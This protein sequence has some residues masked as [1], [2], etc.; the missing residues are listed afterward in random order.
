MSKSS[1]SF[2]ANVL[3]LVT[4]SVFAQGLGVLVAPIVARLFAPEAFGVAALFTSIA[5]IIGVVACLRYQL[6]IM[7]P[8]TDEEAA[9]LLG[10]SLFF[11]LIITGISVLIIFFTGDVIAGMLNSQE[12]KKFLWLVPVSVFVSGIFLALNYWNSRTKQFGRF[13][14]ATVI[15]SV[16]AQTTKLGAGFAGFV[17]G[18]TLIG[19]SILG[20]IVSTFVLGGQIWRDD[21]HLFK[22]SIRWKKMIAGL[23]RHKKF[24]IYSTWS[25]LLNTASQQLP[26]LLLAFYFSPKIVGF[27]ALG[28]AVLSMPMGLVGGAVAQVFF[29]K[30]SE[31]HNHTGNLSKVVEEV[32]K[33]LVSLGIFPILLLTLIGKDLFIV[34]FG[35]RWAEAGVYMQILGLWIFFQFISSPI[36]TLFAVLEKQHYGLLFNSVLFVTRAASLIVGGMT[37]DVRFTLL[38]FASTGVACY[39]FLCFWLISKAELPVMRAFYQIVKYSIYSSPLLISIALVKWL[40]GVQEMGVLLLGLCALLVYYF[41]VMRRDKE[42]RKPID[43]LLQRVG[44]IK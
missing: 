35:A 34:A 9:N 17:S 10:V 29:Q 19:T 31:A 28:Q 5:G 38:L 41:L 27:Y 16:V 23:K 7:L 24:P 21:H 44:F 42:L 2:A 22:A 12:L 4:G 36:S 14:I 18:G 37:G 15:S 13:S 30:A 6:A 40:L 25:A 26:A 39:G 43:M 8:K 1:S 20:Q 11:V 33:R 3:K 32:F